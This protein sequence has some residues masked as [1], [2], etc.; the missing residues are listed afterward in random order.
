MN[1]YLFEIKS[2]LKSFLSWSLTIAVVAVVL[3]IGA[4]PAFSQGGEEVI[5]ILESFPKDFAAAFGLTFTSLFTYEGFF[6]FTFTYFML[7]GAIFAL[8]VGLFAFSRER[9]AKCVDFLLTKPQGR[10][11]IFLCKL[12]ASVTLIFANSAVFI[13]LSMLMYSLN[14]GENIGGF[15]LACCCLLFAELFFLSV[16]IVTAVLLKK[17]RSVSAFASAIGFA[18][19]IVMAIGNILEEPALDFFSPLKYY[20]PSILLMGGSLD[21]P[22][23]LTGAAVFVLCLI[24]AYVFYIKSDIH[25][26]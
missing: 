4:Y 13:V 6:S 3:I 25:A 20:S 22:L 5:K 7:F 15:F 18:A 19:F 24:T 8:S 11:S 14:S 12:L 23:A 1:I 17:I 21:L 26:V 9:R 16:G 10:T 2:Q